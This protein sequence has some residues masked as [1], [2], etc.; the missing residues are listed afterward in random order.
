LILF[1]WKISA[2]WYCPAEFDIGEH[3]KIGVLSVTEGDDKIEKYPLLF[4]QAKA[5]VIT[6][7]ALHPYT[8]FDLGRA[9]VEFP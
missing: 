4:S 5:L 1:L 9:E 2:I 7:M 3:A 8:N 6:K